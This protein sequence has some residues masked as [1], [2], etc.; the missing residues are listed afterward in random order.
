MLRWL[1]SIV[2]NHIEVIRCILSLSQAFV[3]INMSAI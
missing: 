1:Q 3:H 2:L